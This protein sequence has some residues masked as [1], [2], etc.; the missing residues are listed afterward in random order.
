M[1]VV[2]CAMGRL[3]QAWERILGDATLASYHRL[4][5][6]IWVTDASVLRSLS[7]HGQPGWR[8]TLANYA[9]NITAL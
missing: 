8:A 3:K 2:L 9:G 1:H 7:G 6:L 4:R 5:K